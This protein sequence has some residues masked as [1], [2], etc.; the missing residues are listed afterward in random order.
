MRGSRLRRYDDQDAYG[1]HEA[2][3]PDHRGRLAAEPGPPGSAARS[4]RPGRRQR[5]NPHAERAPGI[6]K[7]SATRKVVTEIKPPGRPRFD[8]RVNVFSDTR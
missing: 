7:P 3:L 8:I 4:K 1:Q 5:P 2:Q 6:A